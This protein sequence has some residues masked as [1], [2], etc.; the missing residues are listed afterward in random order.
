MKREWRDGGTLAA[1]AGCEV[2]LAEDNEEAALEASVETVF[3]L[4]HERQH[5]TVG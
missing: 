1:G 2:V 4:R 3:W 5:R